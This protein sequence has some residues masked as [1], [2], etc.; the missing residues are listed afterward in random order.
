MPSLAP[1]VNAITTR[2]KINPLGSKHLR[3]NHTPPVARQSVM[4]TLDKFL[5]SKSLA[6]RD[7]SLEPKQRHKPLHKKDLR[8][9]FGSDRLGSRKPAHHCRRR[10]AQLPPCIGTGTAR[11]YLTGRI[12]RIR[13]TATRK[14]VAQRGMHRQEREGSLHGSWRLG[15]LPLALSQQSQTPD[16]DE[17]LDPNYVHLSGDFFRGNDRALA[18]SRAAPA[19]CFPVFGRPCGRVPERPRPALPW[20]SLIHG[21]LAP[22]RVKKDAIPIVVLDEAPTYAD[23]THVGCFKILNRE[24][25][26]RRK[27]S[28]LLPVDPNI[29]RCAR[30]AVPAVGAFKPQALMKPHF[31][32]HV[33]TRSFPRLV[34]RSRTGGIRP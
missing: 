2:V 22:L 1:S 7:H 27:A 18:A 9:K 15:W 26:R 10:N 31:V 30:T 8:L 25:N 17:A 24:P 23:L 13:T 21:A 6:R 34:S 16:M 14:T 20:P 11:L 5:M 4:P 12:R 3:P 19:G 29:A 33:T 32:A 28:Y